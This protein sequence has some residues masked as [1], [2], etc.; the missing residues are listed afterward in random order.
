M[1]AIQ[2]PMLAV[3]KKILAERYITHL[4]PLLGNGKQEDKVEKQ[5]S[6]AFSAFVVQSLFGLT[7]KAAAQTVVDD[8]EDG[9][10]DAIYRDKADNNELDTLYFIQTKLKETEQFALDEALKFAQGIRLLLISGDFSNFNKNIINRQ[11]EIEEA[12]SDCSHIRLIVAYVGDGV[13]LHAKQALNGLIND[14]RQEDDRLSQDIKYYDA[15]EAE[16]ALIKEQAIKPIKAKITLH[17]YR[18]IEVPRTTLF[19]LVKI[20]DLIALNT[21][22]GKALYEKNIRYFIGAGPRGVNRAIKSTLEKNPQDF[23]YLNN[24]VTAVATRIETKKY[25]NSSNSKTCVLSGFSII[26]GAQT[27]ASSA[28]FKSENPNADISEARVMMT[29]IEASEQGNFHKQVT[30]SR[31]LQNPVDMSNFAALDE[32]QE[33]LKKEIALYSIE[34]RYRPESSKNLGVEIVELDEL[35]KALACLDMNN[36]NPYILKIEP[37]QFTY[38]EHEKYKSIFSKDLLGSHAINSVRAYRIIKNLLYNAEKTTISPEKLVYRHCIYPLS[39]ILMKKLRD[40][41][42][43]SEVFSQHDLAKFISLDFDEIR[44]NCTDVYHKNYSHRAPHSFFKQVETAVFANKVMIK[45]QNMDDDQTVKNLA[46]RYDVNDPYN[47][48]L[49]NY[50]VGKLKQI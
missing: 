30:R 22:H 32:I 28:Q 5:I 27:V 40:K 3:L 8:F 4:P 10:I 16:A 34:Y 45:T 39:F 47:Q 37:S 6:R 38:L 49:T 18:K 43:G 48:A 41:I 44:Q 46:G 13:S 23:F 42:K 19:G 14:V 35:S 26:N 21:E 15:L 20:E 33:R 11:Q 29:V 1:A 7:N 50:L 31:N 9:G 24:G 36:R 17:H 12:L 25:N 2:K